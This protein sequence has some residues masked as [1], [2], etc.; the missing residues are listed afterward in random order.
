M[1]TQVVGIIST[2]GESSVYRNGSSLALSVQR[3]MTLHPPQLFPPTLL[4]DNG[5]CLNNVTLK[6]INPLF[7]D[8]NGILV[9]KLVDDFVCTL[10]SRIENS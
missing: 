3:G 5:Y 6:K 2:E 8:G 1:D 4:K 9:M 10:I 7:C